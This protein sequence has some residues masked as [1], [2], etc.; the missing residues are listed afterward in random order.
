MMRNP[1]GY[2]DPTAGMALRNIEHKERAARLGYMP[3]TY[4]CL[5]TDATRMTDEAKRYCT[6]ALSKG[7]LPI[8]PCLLFPQAEKDDARERNLYMSLILLK[9]CQ[10][11]WYF[12]E[13][14]DEDMRTVL[15]KAARRDMIVRRFTSDCREADTYDLRVDFQEAVL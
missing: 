4:I 6:F 2:P 7:V 1:E 15:R 12:G 5:P 8:V 10:E 3:L 11:V 9:Y 14:V 13:V